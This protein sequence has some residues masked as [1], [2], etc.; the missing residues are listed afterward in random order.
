MDAAYMPASYTNYD[1]YVDI[2]A[3]G[4]DADYHQ[5]HNGSVYSTLPP[6]KSGGTGYGYMDGT[7]MA[8]PHVSGVAALG[9]SYAVKLRKHFTADQFKALLL[10]ATRDVENE[11]DADGNSLW[12][13]TGK[14]YYKYFA[15]A[16]ESSPVRMELDKYYKGKMGDLIDA[17]KLLDLVEG[18]GVILELPNLYVATGTENK[19]TVNLAHFLITV[20]I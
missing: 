5:T 4:G 1:R 10:Q 17:N 13:K 9:L 7:S 12:P 15:E 16:G 3:P 14:L 8:C 6:N 20:M 18:N 19:Q 2:M 11:Y